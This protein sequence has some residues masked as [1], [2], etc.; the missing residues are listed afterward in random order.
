MQTFDFE[1]LPQPDDTACGPTCLHAVY[2]YYRDGLGLED[3]I[4]G[5]PSLANGGTLAVLLACHALARGYK[6][7]IYTYNL[8]LF[9]PSWF[10]PPRSDLRAK[11]AAQARAK[12]HERLRVATEGYLRFLE[13]GGCVAFEPLTR[14]VIARLLRAGTPVLTGLSATYLYGEPRETP[15]GRSDD[16]GGYA[17][18]HFVVLYG[19]DGQRHEVM[20]ADPLQSNPH[21]ATHRYAMDIDIVLGAILLGVVTYDANLLIVEPSAAKKAPAEN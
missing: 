15:D 7:T 12:Q 8:Q 1:I 16:V 21:S 17:Q 13:L 5:V 9:D 4:A 10:V 11:L 19:Y 20:I 18:G 3:V 6:A 2:Q 14:R